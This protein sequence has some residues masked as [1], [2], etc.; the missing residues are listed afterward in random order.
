[1]GAF[2][3]SL[4]RGGRGLIVCTEGV[5]DAGSGPVAGVGS[6]DSVNEGS[7]DG[8]KRVGVF[9]SVKFAV[10]DAM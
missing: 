10:A 9:S 1:V 6:F 4:G 8:Y 7:E 5:A 3:G 2:D